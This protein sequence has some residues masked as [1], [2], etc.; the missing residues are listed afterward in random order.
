M[1]RSR[2]RILHDKE[3]SDLF[4]ETVF[5]IRGLCS[6]IREQRKLGINPADITFDEIKPFIISCPDI[7]KYERISRENEHK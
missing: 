7:E 1:Q 3:I 6:Y 2:S 5:D 4:R